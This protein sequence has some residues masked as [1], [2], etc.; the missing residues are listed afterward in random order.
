MNIR[1]QY[2][3]GTVEVFEEQSR[4]GGSYRTR[5]KCEGGFLLITDVWGNVTGI[6]ES[7]IL[8]FSTNG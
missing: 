6:P 1:I 7:R 8:K 2:T 3:D 5:Y 4:A